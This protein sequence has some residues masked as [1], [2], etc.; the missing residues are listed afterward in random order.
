M[1]VHKA[2]GLA[3]PVTIVVAGDNP[4]AKSRGTFLWSWAR[5][6]G[7]ALPAALL[8]VTDMK[9]TVLDDEAEA[10]LDAALLDQMNIVYVA[11]T[12]P[13]ER[14]DVLAETAKMDFERDEP[15]P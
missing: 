9:D 13:V 4:A 1:T 10:E 2:K 5:Q 7:T 8:K 12:R 14:L 3:F 11:M 15:G 6:T